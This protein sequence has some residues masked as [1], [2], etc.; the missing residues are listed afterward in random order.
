MS[1]TVTKSSAA[2]AAAVTEED[3]AAI[4]RQALRPLSAEEVFVFHV[5]ACDDCVDRD[6]ERFPLASLEKL[7]SLFVG[8]PVIT[9]H[10][11]RAGNQTARVFRG[12]VET[13]TDGRSVLRLDCYMLRTERTGETIAAIEGGILREVSVGCSVSETRCCICGKRWLDCPHLPGSVYDGETCVYELIDPSEAYEL[14]FVAV[15]AQRNAGVTKSAK[16]NPSGWTPA[17]LAVEK[18][19]LNLEK[20]RTEHYERIC[21]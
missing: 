17:D 12:S 9:D 20:E 16:N 4:N 5:N 18:I 19:R 14:S 6:F 13:Q 15:P 2:S 1:L 21:Q 10:E 7:A 8:K 3:L 11:W